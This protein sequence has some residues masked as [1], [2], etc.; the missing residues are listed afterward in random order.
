MEEYAYI[1]PSL[2]AL[3]DGITVPTAN[4]P[5]QNEVEYED[6]VDSGKNDSSQP[7]DTHCNSKLRVPSLTQFDR[8][9]V[10][11]ASFKSR[12][13]VQHLSD[14]P[15]TAATMGQHVRRL[16]PSIAFIVRFDLADRNHHGPHHDDQKD[17]FQSLPC[18]SHRTPD[19]QRRL[20]ASMVRDS[21]VY[22]RSGGRREETRLSRRPHPLADLIW[23]SE[24]WQPT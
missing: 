20:V 17:A 12:P 1:P 14:A 7:Y 6:G 15:P 22:S 4:V 2:P 5:Y 10:S 18:R 19:R 11:Q 8:A 13:Y 9:R 23:H 3:I 16:L 24:Q 21:E